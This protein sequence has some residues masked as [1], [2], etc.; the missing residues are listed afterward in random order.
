[1][2]SAIPPTP[3]ANAAQVAAA[4]ANVVT[5]TGGAE[6]L[7]KLPQGALISAM[8]TEV[9][10]RNQ[11]EITTAD[12]LTLSLRL[13][14]GLQLPADADLSL[15]LL[16]SSGLPTLKLLAVNG[17]PLG[18]ALT[19]QLGGQ[20]PVL[21]GGDLPFGVLGGAASPGPGRGAAVTLG[22]NLPPPPGSAGAA[23][24]LPGQAGLA[25]GP[26]GL[27]ATVL[28]SGP[29]EAALAPQSPGMP[30]GSL[31]PVLTNLAPGTQLT[32][33]IAGLAPPQGGG[34]SFPPPP[35][36][37]PPVLSGAAVTN[38]PSAAGAAPQLSAPVIPGVGQQVSTPPAALASAPAAAVVPPRAEQGPP[39]LPGV[40]A[41]QSGPVPSVAAPVAMP[42]AVIS[43]A[44]GGN[45]L[46]QT[47][48]GLLSLQTNAP[49]ANGSQVTLEVVGP[50]VPPPQSQSSGSSGLGPAGWP[51][52]T[53][54]SEALAQSD[55]QAAEQLMRMIPQTG[56][57]LAAAMSVF[58]SAV[59]SGDVKALVGEGV[60]RGL[61]KAGRRDLAERLKKDLDSL[62]EESSRPL[63]NGDWRALTLPV[64]HGAHVDP[65]RLYLHRP[66][67]EEEG[68]GKHNTQEQRFILDVNM[69]QL[70]RIQLDGLVMRDSQRFD[71]II[72]T[73]Q[74][75]SPTICRDIAG[76]FAECG[77][78]TGAKGSVSFQS[79]GRFVDLPPTAA[80]GTRIVV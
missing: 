76:I 80:S 35:S 46:I 5:V 74:P 55:R 29:V 40:T 75:L 69:T 2:S 11:V 44:G 25:S 34:A 6:V 4:A 70:G 57:R 14:P 64:I 66:N 77:Q 54:A 12:G 62:S 63:G 26:L 78:L 23:A 48:A 65:V 17:R 22:Q 71:L 19:P 37:A 20:A 53:S 43:H 68:G 28:R 32:V 51:T 15:Q 79:G 52:L 8:L 72:R 42:G 18:T 38:V 21:P 13:P 9:A 49:L 58:A 16:Q 10:S 7:A 41:P 33:R 27:A 30:P 36:L 45:T 50:P 24:L 56:P 73:A 67:A 47:P 1:M 60:T 31:P 3:P 39:P 59:R 61:D